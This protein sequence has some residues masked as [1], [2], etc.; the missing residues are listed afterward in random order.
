MSREAMLARDKALEL[1]TPYAPLA[2]FGDI[3]AWA[4]VFLGLGL[5]FIA[6][7]DR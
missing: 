2:Q 4:Y 5:A 3:P 7:L 1:A 6:S